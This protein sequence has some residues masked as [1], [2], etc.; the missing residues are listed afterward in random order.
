MKKHLPNDEQSQIRSRL[1][2]SIEAIL[3]AESKKYG[4][5]HTSLLNS[6]EMDYSIEQ[7]TTLISNK[8]ANRKYRY[9][10]L[11]KKKVA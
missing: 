2:V 7:M 8:L 6:S 10:R 5:D 4:F 9:N 11:E 3:M 1:K